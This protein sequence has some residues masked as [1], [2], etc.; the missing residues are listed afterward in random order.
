[1][2]A[3]ITHKLVTTFTSSS[4][5]EAILSSEPTTKDVVG[6]KFQC[7]VHHMVWGVHSAQEYHLGAS[8]K[9]ADKQDKEKKN[10][11][12]DRALSYAATTAA[13]IAGDP[14]FTAFI[15]K[16]SEDEE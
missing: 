5:C 3:T 14:G 16:L 11:P 13:M 1:M 12:K 15:S 2:Y 7:C 10:K 6:K 4:M 8:C 9:D